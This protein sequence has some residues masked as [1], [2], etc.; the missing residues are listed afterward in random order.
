M[1]KLLFW[2]INRKALE[3]IVA[4]LAMKHGVDVLVLAECL[5]TTEVMLSAL[6]QR[7]AQYYYSPYSQ[8]EQ[9]AIYT[10]FSRHFLQLVSET[11][12]WTIRRLMLPE[13]TEILWR[14]FICPASFIGRRRVSTLN[15]QS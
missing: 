12:R 9:I 6:N 11:T 8:C 15:A 14:L 4:N 5:P 1:V 13:R 10:R 3:Q 2:N 7:Q